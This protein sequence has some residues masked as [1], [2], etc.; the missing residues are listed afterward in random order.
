MTYLGA[1]RVPNEWNGSDV[2]TLNY[3]GNALGFNP[4]RGGSGSLFISCFSP[5]NLVSEISI[6]T[7]VRSTNVADLPTASTLQPCQDSTAGGTV[8]TG[9]DSTMIGG[10]LVYNHQLYTTK[11]V[12]YD[13]TSSQTNAFYRKANTNLAQ[14]NAVGAARVEAGLNEGFVDGAM[15]PIPAKWQ[16]AL[17]GTVAVGNNSL[18][19]ITR[20]SWGPAAFG[21]NPASFVN[22]TT[23]SPATPLV[24]Y[25]DAHPTL[26]TWNGPTPNFTS[27]WW[28]MAGTNGYP[29]MVIPEGYSSVLYFGAQ[30]MGPFC[31]GEGTADPALAGHST[32]DGSVWCYDPVNDSKGTHGYPYRYQVMAYDLSD[33]AEVAAGKKLPYDVVPY[34]VWPLTAGY[35][36]MDGKTNQ[37]AGGAV[38][39]PV[40]RRIY[41]SAPG[42]DRL[43][44]YSSMPLVHVWQLR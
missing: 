35:P 27:S 13:A 1:F 41:F 34:D 5:G 15:S 43:A 20:T 25:S 4:D 12:Y 29:G 42:S 9:G 30:G 44:Q 2:T 38:F 22:A 32:P 16:S 21:W 17:H 3:G 8:S 37:M 36:A 24:Y 19:I 11:Y 26:G 31:Y 14:A 33:L 40:S 18:S 28:N 23:P 10:L 39:D 7:P 6:P